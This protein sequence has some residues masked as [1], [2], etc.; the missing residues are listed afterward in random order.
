MESPVLPIPIK[1]MRF[2]LCAT[3]LLRKLFKMDFEGLHNPIDPILELGIK[4]AKSQKD[5]EM[6]DTH[7]PTAA[8]TIKELGVLSTIQEIKDPESSRFHVFSPLLTEAQDVILL[9]TLRIHAHRFKWASFESVHNIQYIQ[10]LSNLRYMNINVIDNLT[11]LNNISFLFKTN[12]ANLY[13]LSIGISPEISPIN[14]FIIALKNVSSLLFLRLSGE[15]SQEEI[16]AIAKVVAT[17][18]SLVYL[19]FHNSSIESESIYDILVAVCDHAV[20][21]TLDLK[22]TITNGFFLEELADCIKR[23][24][25]LN[26]VIV[27]DTYSLAGPILSS[28][29]RNTVFLQCLE[30][31]PD[32]SEDIRNMFK[33]TFITES[34]SSEDEVIHQHCQKNLKMQLLADIRCQSHLKLLINLRLFSPFIPAKLL[35]RIARPLFSFFRDRQ[36]EVVSKAIF[37]RSRRFLISSPFPFSAREFLKRCYS[38]CFIRQDFDSKLIENE[39]RNPDSPIFSH[40]YSKRKV[41]KQAVY[42]F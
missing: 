24:Y 41:S 1:C 12:L 6:L 18:K 20:I 27:D 40:Q 31:S 7:T 23:S 4:L 22:G 19:G 26:H 36:F 38:I 3:D 29:V 42:N 21:R 32:N 14:S 34:F 30:I 39:I 16:G 35:S 5:G 15:F 8:V 25:S 2:I 37:D 28:V 17:N 11:I 13:G 33:N 10:V 9:K